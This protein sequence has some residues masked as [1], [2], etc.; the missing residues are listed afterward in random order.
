M[1]ARMHRPSLASPARRQRPRLLPSALDILIK[2]VHRLQKRLLLG[3]PLAPVGHVRAARESML[4][5]AVQVHL[6]RHS[7][8]LQDAL[9]GVALVGGEDGVGLGG[10]DGQRARDGAQLGFVDEGRV[11][12][13]AGVGAGG[14]AADVA[15]E[16]GDVLGGVRGERERGGGG[17]GPCRRSSSRRCRVS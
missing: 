13:V 9:A 7:R 15:E 11:R 17:E 1:P 14:G 16:A 6:V 12:R 5:V 3:E 10:G 8:L 2:P 4:D